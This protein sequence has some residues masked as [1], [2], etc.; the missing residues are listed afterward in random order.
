[1]KNKFD[2]VI[3]F[4]IDNPESL[5][6][7]KKNVDINSLE[8]RKVLYGMFVG[9]REKHVALVR[10]STIPDEAVSMILKAA[11]GY[12]D[13]EL[14]RIKI[15]HQYSMSAENLVG[16]LLEKYLAEK[17]EPHGWVW[18]SGDFVKAVDFI[19]KDEYGIWHA[20]QIKNRDNTENSSSSAIRKG[21]T[22]EKWFRTFSKPSLKRDTNT[23]WDAFPEARF[24]E[25]LSEDDF[26]SYIKNLVSSGSIYS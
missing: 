14:E 22:I 19:K 26:L 16:Y 21:T 4:L 9:D 1:M 23:N 12:S 3:D 25:L 13:E 7:R 15:E 24:V 5:S 11:N 8:G 20:L 10:P 18:C 2:I 17:L 6:G